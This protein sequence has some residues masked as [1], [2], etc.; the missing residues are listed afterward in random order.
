[1]VKKSW[2]LD[3]QI[4]VHAIENKD[5]KVIN[6]NKFDHFIVSL[7]SGMASNSQIPSENQTHAY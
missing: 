6:L 5:T 3:C 4:M 7:F 2:D 1:M